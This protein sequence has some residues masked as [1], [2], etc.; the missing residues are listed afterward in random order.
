MRSKRH[1][2]EKALATQRLLIVGLALVLGWVAFRATARSLQAA[3]FTAANETELIAAINS[4]NAAGAGD[5]LITFTADITLTAALP[6]ISNPTAASITLAGDGHTLT[7]DGAHTVLA[8]AD[9]STVIV[10]ELNVTGGSGSSGAAGT[11]GGGFFNRGDLTISESTVSGNSA[12]LGGGILNE[13]SPGTLAKTT[14]L[15]ST[16]SANTAT[17]G[18]AIA[19]LSAGGEAEVSLDRVTL[20][21]NTAQQDGGGVH[22]Q[23][24]Q[25]GTARLSVVRT[26][27]T[28]NESS[29]AGGGGIANLAANGALAKLTI[30]RSQL[31]GNSSAT[32]GGGLLLGATSGGKSDTFINQATLAQNT[33]L[34]GGGGVHQAISGGSASFNATN[35]TVSGNAG[36]TVG[37][38]IV[39]RSDGGTA[40]MRLIHA[41]IAGNSATTGRGLYTATNGGAAIVT[42]GSSIITG[43]DADCAQAGGMITSANF[44]VASD[45]SCGLSA[46][47]DVSGVDP[48]ILPLAA[49]APSTLLTH[50]LQVNSPAVDRATQTYNGCDTTTLT[51]ER[52]AARMQG[53]RCD[54]GAYELDKAPLECV[55]PYNVNSDAALN[56]AI[57]CINDAGPGSHTIT[58]TGA[59]TLVAPATPI[60]NTEATQILV[61][62]NSQQINADG[63]GTALAVLDG[64]TVRMV[65]LTITGGQGTSGVDA[66]GGGGLY[67]RGQVNLDGITVSGN[68]AAV[69]GGI[70]VDG[71]AGDATLIF[72]DGQLTGNSAE[73]SGGGLAVTGNSGAA[74]ITIAASAINGNTS[75]DT[76]GGVALAGYNGAATASLTDTSVAGNSAVVGGGVFVN[77]NGAS[78]TAAMDIARSTIS[79]NNATS[80]GGLSL[81]GNQGDATVTLLNSTVSGNSAT[82]NGGGVSNAGN[83]GTAALEA[84]FTTFANNTAGSGAI[85]H[86]SGGATATIAASIIA[87]ADTKALCVIVGGA[88]SSGDYNVGTDATCNLTQPHDV[89]NG[90]P[91]LLPLAL[92]AP[93]LTQT[94]ALSAGSDALDHI[95]GG[96]VGCGTT[97]ANDQRGIG[98]PSPTGGQCDSGSYELGQL[99]PE[100]THRVYLPVSLR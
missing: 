86:S 72:Q 82:K 60:N 13:S 14:V 91:N 50:A 37:G 43:T 74:A 30:L 62:G 78:A 35:F 18:G 41:T 16:V 81:D 32:Q 40:G 8:I 4:A 56:R 71:E 38:G 79:G 67:V 36:G 61:S 80:G 98:R 20:A 47:T 34:T 58:L 44:N 45:A 90:Q 59:V 75:G 94:H 21:G 95:P 54:S 68:D 31:T 1:L 93:G 92:N 2:S 85:V 27:V 17:S 5:H 42:L 28:D 15:S 33:A 46:P 88:V 9:D 22:N 76:G 66:N 97:V 69:G 19:N 49:N 51:D 73:T 100:V 87:G 55:G 48:Q 70:L 29:Q 6:A 10:N 57:L 25:S 53:I 12:A 99:P 52:G 77:G 96:S 65:E 64:T 83:G 63:K 24:E 39:N 7:G 26:Q 11:G 89:A 3:A 84:S 23:G